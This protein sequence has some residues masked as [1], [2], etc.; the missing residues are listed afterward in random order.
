MRIKYTMYTP[1]VK[2]PKIMNAPKRFKDFL[3]SGKTNPTIIVEVQRTKEETEI[4]NRSEISL[5]YTH[6]TAPRLSYHPN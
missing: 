2:Q 1:T 6:V 4:E 5:L 3:I